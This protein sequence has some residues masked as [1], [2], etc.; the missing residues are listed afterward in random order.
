MNAIEKIDQKLKKDHPEVKIISSN[1]DNIEVEL[2]DEAIRI[3]V[4]AYDLFSKILEYYKGDSNI[5]LKLNYSSIYFK[6]KLIFFTQME[7]KYRDALFT[8]FGIDIEKEEF[9]CI[10]NGRKFSIEMGNLKDLNSYGSD[11]F[12]DF[13]EK[14]E[15]EDLDIDLHLGGILINLISG[16][17]NPIEYYLRINNDLDPLNKRI[18]TEKIIHLVNFAIFEFY[19]NKGIMFRLVDSSIDS[20]SF[21]DYRSYNISKKVVK[22]IEVG[23]YR[24]IDPFLL[25]MIYEG[26]ITPSPFF[27]FLS[28]Y[29]VFE[30]FYDKAPM[31]NVIKDIRKIIIK[32]EF[33]SDLEGYTKKIY[34]IVRNNTSRV[35]EVDKLKDL[36]IEFIEPDI[37]D[38]IDV[39]ITD[40]MKKR[41]I[42]DGGLE[43]PSII[44]KGSLN[45]KT[46]ANRIYDLRRAIVHSNPNFWKK[47]KKPIQYT[48][49]NFEYVWIESSFLSIL[50]VELIGKA[51]LDFYKSLTGSIK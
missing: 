11:N 30:Y 3:K 40:H 14:M 29:R 8:L 18:I 51:T 15:K 23:I 19:R 1:L 50:S 34:E 4:E 36:L 47:Y 38:K 25:D 41:I 45:W 5:V 39:K 43:L 13:I 35:S 6:N 28:Y 44:N 21:I 42:L 7:R 20:Q 32:P 22:P 24:Y 31:G 49:K 9:D 37:L 12:N 48:K 46:C 10:F 17:D 27:K 33:A 26:D 2:F 16:S